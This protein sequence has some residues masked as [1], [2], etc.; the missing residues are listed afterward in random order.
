MRATF[1]PTG[2]RF[3]F[4]DRYFVQVKSAGAIVDGGTKFV[5][6][7]STLDDAQ[8]FAKAQIE[9]IDIEAAWVFTREEQVSA[10]Y[11]E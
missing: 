4:D 11:A 2:Y 8:D 9:K 5:A 3:T 6:A 7:F 10:Y 1:K